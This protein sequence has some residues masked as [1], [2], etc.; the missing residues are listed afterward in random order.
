MSQTDQE[1][2][3]NAIRRHWPYPPGDKAQS[4]VGKFFGA[5]RFGCKIVARV[6]GNYGTYTVSVQAT[7]TGV[8]SACSRGG[9]I[10]APTT[11][12]NTAAVT[13]ATP[14]P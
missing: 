5:T 1:R 7:E 13:I 6:E 11:S 4:Y 14:W 12:A 10:P 3:Q 2:L 8:T 9:G